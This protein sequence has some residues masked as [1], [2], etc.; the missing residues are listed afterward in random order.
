[1]VGEAQTAAAALI[2]C[3][4]LQPDIVLLDISMPD[5]GGIAVIGQIVEQSP[6]TRVI[7]LSMHDDAQY[8]RGAL[9]AGAKGYVLKDAGG[10]EIV[11]AIHAVTAGGT[12]FSEAMSQQLLA[13]DV[14]EGETSTLTEREIEVLRL[15]AAGLTNKHIARQLD[16][17]PRTVESHRANIKSKLGASSFAEMLRYAVEQGL[18]AD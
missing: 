8:L 9:R 17:S 4:S 7:I 16:I 12:Y 10:V 6:A 15:L 1:M 5:Q 13:G 2:V 14:D 18:I 11:R 3:A